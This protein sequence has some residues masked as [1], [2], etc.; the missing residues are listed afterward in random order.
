MQK[1]VF[2][3]SNPAL[4]NK[5]KWFFKNKL[6]LDYSKNKRVSLWMTSDLN[7]RSNCLYQVTGQ[8]KYMP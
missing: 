5:Y 7:D 4:I 1:S 2:D 6:T 3:N 8:K